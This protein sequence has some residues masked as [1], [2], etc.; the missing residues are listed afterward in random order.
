MVFFLIILSVYGGLNFYVYQT[1]ASGLGGGSWMTATVVTIFAAAPFSLR[2]TEGKLPHWLLQLK[3]V[4]GYNWMGICWL[5]FSCTVVL[6]LLA[7][8]FPAISAQDVLT[9]GTACAAL[10]TFYGFASARNVQEKRLEILSPKFNDDQ[11]DRFR[12]IQISDIHLGW[13]SQ[14]EFISKLVDRINDLQPDLIVSTGD[15]YDSDLENL[16]EFVEIVKGFAAPK[17]KLGVTGNHEVYSDLGKALELTAESEVELLRFDSKNIDDWL[18][19]VGADDPEVPAQENDEKMENKMLEK[20]DSKRFVLLLKHRP[21]I[22]EASIGRFDLQLSGHTHGGQIFPFKLLTKLQYQASN[23][24]SRLSPRSYLYLSRG[25]GTW[26]P[27]IRFLAP[28]EFTV[29]DIRKADDFE[30]REA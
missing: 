19:V 17:G 4:I 12:I 1:I 3:A 26:G 16:Q 9:V 27:K 20:V 21:S 5:F 29:F 22:N 2:L 28:P 24:L 13:G 23:G 18:T 7:L 11:K 30:I 8:V 6:R 25:T 10:T 15:L 14:K